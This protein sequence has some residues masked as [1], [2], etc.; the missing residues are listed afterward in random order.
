MPRL[1]LLSRLPVIDRLAGARHG[2]GRDIDDT[3][4]APTRRKRNASLRGSRPPPEEAASSAEPWSNPEA[5]REVDGVEPVD[6]VRSG[7]C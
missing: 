6:L 3:A 1:A 5:D 4:I 7:R 2:D